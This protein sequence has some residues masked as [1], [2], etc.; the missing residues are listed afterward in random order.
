MA[1]HA[2][3]RRRTAPIHPRR[4]SGPMRPSA[5]PAVALPAPGPFERLRALPD[6]RVVDRLLRGRLC[7]WVIGVLL[8]GIVAMQV[9][10]LRMNA[11]ISRAVSTASLLEQRNSDL[12]ASI[13]RATTGEKVREAAINDGM[14]DPAAGE[15]S[16]L[17]ARPSIDARLAVKHMKPPSENAINVM[18]G[19]GKLPSTTV[20]LAGTA[21]TTAAQTTPVATPARTTPVATP[22]PAPTVTQAQVTP[23]P[24]PVATTVPGTGGAAIAPQG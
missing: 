9:S 7:I 3:A 24:T 15:T 22:T 16:F 21:A 1:Q 23:T 5:V 20:P 19:G 6:K 11:G 13:A 4:I 10:L 17:T 18:A 2:P 12:E 14:I 8:G